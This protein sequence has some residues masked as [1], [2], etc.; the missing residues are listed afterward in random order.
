MINLNFQSMRFPCFEM[1][2]QEDDELVQRIVARLQIR[3]GRQVRDLKVSAR[4][5]GLVLRGEVESYYG[6]LLAQ[7]VVSE[8]SGQLILANNIEVECRGTA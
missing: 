7:K 8:V 6:K 1:L 3:M 2:L 5:D 4:E